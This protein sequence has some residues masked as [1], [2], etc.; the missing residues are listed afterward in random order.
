V[1]FEEKW[2]FPMFPGRGYRE[3]KEG[4]RTLY[5]DGLGL[6]E[7]SQSKAEEG[8]EE[9][10]V[11]KWEHGDRTVMKMV[12]RGVAVKLVGGLHPTELLEMLRS[13]APREDRDSSDSE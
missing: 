1:G 8:A 13:L 9:Q 4:L 10:V 5:S 2:S 3:R 6:I 11:L 12:Y 7:L